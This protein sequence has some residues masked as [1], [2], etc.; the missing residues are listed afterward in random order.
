MLETP[1]DSMI[2]YHL[3]SGTLSDDVCGRLLCMP[4]K[5]SEDAI[6][7]RRADETSKS[8]CKT[9]QLRVKCMLTV[10]R[11]QNIHR[12]IP[13]QELQAIQTDPEKTHQDILNP[14]PYAAEKSV[15]D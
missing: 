10:N 11:H 8:N 2:R 5:Q 1:T 15:A 13:N 4:D 7:I 14:V 12:A 9:C 3:L 6:L